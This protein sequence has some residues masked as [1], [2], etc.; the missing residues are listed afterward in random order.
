MLRR[1]LMVW[2]ACSK[3]IMYV[4]VYDAYFLLVG[5]TNK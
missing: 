5:G 3:Y 1:K 2:D 4:C